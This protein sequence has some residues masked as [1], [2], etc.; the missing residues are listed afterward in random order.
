MGTKEGSLILLGILKT[1]LRFNGDTF[2]DI[3]I[4]S[5]RIS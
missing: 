5:L 4:S 3:E 2:R 1:L